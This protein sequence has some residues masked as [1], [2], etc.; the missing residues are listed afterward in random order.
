[1]P[2]RGGRYPPI[3]V[4]QLFGGVGPIL[5]SKVEQ[6]FFRF[7]LDAMSVPEALA[8]TI[9]GLAV[10]L[11]CYLLIKS[12]IGAEGVGGA[13]GAYNLAW[14][15]LSRPTPF[16]FATV[17]KTKFTRPPGHAMWGG[18]D[19]PPFGGSPR[20]ITPCSS[21]GCIEAPGGRLSDFGGDGR[22]CQRRGSQIPPARPWALRC[23]RAPSAHSPGSIRGSRT[24]SARS[25][26]YNLAR[27]SP[28]EPG[29][30]TTWH[31]TP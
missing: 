27:R 10:W 21:P 16:S 30:H 31:G 3:K 23:P 8:T 15:A 19:H 17:N 20:P 26:A 28:G 1:M 9:C 6:D 25:G 24:P 22:P 14:H 5:C 2:P 13:G 11:L 4:T 29:G 18:W 7:K 12:P